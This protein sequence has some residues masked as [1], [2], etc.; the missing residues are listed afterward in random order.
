[1]TATPITPT[2]RSDMRPVLIVLTSHGQKGS[3]GQATGYYLS[4]VTHPLAVLHEAGLVVEFASI[5]G[6]EPPVDGLDLNDAV[7]ARYWA[8]EGFR[9]AVRTTPP[10]ADVDPGR[11]SAVLF[12]GGHGT[13]W[14]FPDSPAVQTL[15]RA[16]Y[17]Q[18][19]VVAAVCHGPSALVNVRLTGGAYLVSGK[20]VA[21]FTD[22]EEQ[23]VGLTE[24]VPFL[25]A[26]TLQLRGAL[27]QAAPNWAEQ[28][29]VD[30]RLVTGQN[31]QSAHG[32]GLALR[33]LL[34]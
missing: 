11:Y 9:Q 8:D 25:L 20:R 15:T 32:V 26:S 1:M 28:V 23:A 17:E 4:E 24:V 33:S 14:D 2:P 12:A 7:N 21:A 27:H 22:A 30:G 29:V 10:L 19:G 18:G 5:L 13:V 3:T 16:V 34:V 31:P 6:G